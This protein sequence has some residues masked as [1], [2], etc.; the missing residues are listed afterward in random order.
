MVSLSVREFFI[1]DNFIEPFGLFSLG[2]WI[3]M[4]SVLIGIILIYK[5][6]NKIR[7]LKKSNKRKIEIIMVFTLFINMKLLYIPLIWYGKWDWMA[8]L[9]L[10]MCFIAGYLFM[11]SVLFKKRNL[12]KI[13]YFLGF[14]GPLPAIILPDLRGYYDAFVFY[15]F[16]VSHHLFMLFNFAYYYMSNSKITIK[17]LYQTFFIANAI[18]LTMF[19]FNVIFGTNYIFSKEIPSHVMDLMPFLNKINNP[20]L[21][22]EIAGLIT[23]LVAYLPIYLENRSKSKLKQ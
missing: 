23:L 9:P 13:V 11:F 19:A 17:N 16:I 8:H 7:K 10:H 14:I 15:Q 1:N 18:F 22:L 5:N 2:H 12:Y 6:R 20:I 4:L 3:M 21:L